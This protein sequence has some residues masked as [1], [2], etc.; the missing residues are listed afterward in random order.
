M[1]D[2]S[3]N[4]TTQ[5]AIFKQTTSFQ[6]SNRKRRDSDFANRGKIINGWS[7]L[8]ISNLNFPPHWLWYLT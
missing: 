6:S 3:S 4:L 5:S 1:P 2:S 7:L 8:P